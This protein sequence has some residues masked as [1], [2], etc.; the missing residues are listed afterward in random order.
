MPTRAKLHATPISGGA[1]PADDVAL[2]TAVITG[3]SL[4]AECLAKKTGVPFGRIDA[5]LGRM[6]QTLTVVITTARCDACLTVT[7]VFRL[8]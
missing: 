7:K 2:V 4:C 6:G 8:P 1:G 3:A 5:A